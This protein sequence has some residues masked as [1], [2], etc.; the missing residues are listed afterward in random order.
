MNLGHPF[1]IYGLCK[2]AGVSLED[3]EVWI[4]PLKAIVVKKDKSGVPRSDAVY[5]S[6]HESSDEKELTAYQTLCVRRPQVWPTPHPP[7]LHPTHPPPPLP[8]VEPAITS[9][10]PTLKDQVQDLTTRLDTLWDETRSIESPSARIWMPYGPTCAKYF[11]ISRSSSNNSHSCLHYM[12]HQHHRHR[13]D[14]R[15][16]HGS[17][18]LSF[19][20]YFKMRTLSIF[21]WGGGGSV[22]GR[23]GIN[24]YRV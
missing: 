1:L 18:L 16:R 17:S 23:V 7:H 8:P 6:G 11:A 13:S 9:T 20:L 21:F 10:S 3:N 22:G 19:F 5:D 24:Y 15:D 4:H 2:N 14:P 12:C